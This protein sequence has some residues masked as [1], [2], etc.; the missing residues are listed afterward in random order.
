[1]TAIEPSTS[2]GLDRSEAAGRF[3]PAAI[4]FWGLAAALLPTMVLASFYFGVTWDEKSRHHYGELVWDFYTGARGM[5]AFPE[6]GGHLYGGL[7]DVLAVAAERVFP[8]NRYEIRHVIG[9]IFG[10]L[11]I[12]YAGRLAGRFFGAW[13]AVITLVLLAPSPRFFGD[14]M[15]NPK[16]LPF[17]AVS[18]VSL[19][20]ISLMSPRWPYLSFGTAVKIA[21][22]V[23]L[24]L[25][26][27]AGALL[28]A[29]Y[30]GMLAGAFFL[31]ERTYDWRRLLNLSLRLL[32]LLAAVLVMGTVAWPWAQQNPFIR[33]IIGLL[34]FSNFDYG[35]M[36]L[37]RGVEYVASEL[38]WT[39]VPTWLAIS[40]PPVVL[41]GVLLSLAPQ[42]AGVRWPRAALWFIVLLP[43]AIVVLRGSTIYDGIRHLLFIYPP[44]VL[45]AASGWAVWLSS[46]V[47]P[48]R[49][50]V[51]GVLLAIGLADVL[52]FNVR[53]FPNQIVY[54][55]QLVGGPKGAFLR[56]DMDYWG[57]CLLEAVDWS[58]A[59]ARR[60]GQP[61][62]V[63]GNPWQLIQLDSDRYK[64]LAFTLPW[65]GTEH[66]TIRLNRGPI[67][68]MRELVSRTDAL[69]QVKTPD[70]AVLCA[71]FPGPAFGQLRPNLARADR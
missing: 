27:R 59:L 9:A 5:E 51:A 61:V 64:E 35:G 43:I 6:T 39:Y 16:D 67:E 20:Y 37:F 71:V 52:I 4:A 55:N 47:G 40:T 38:P 14:A 1:M 3:T 58:A 22:P 19:Y 23:A 28:Y 63:S 17:A 66:V 11:G 36:V 34:G 62:V 7:F 44:L 13:S 53:A 15:N 2:A 41:V 12:V 56:Y 65:R 21:V 54:F 25:S 42:P 46:A 8:G 69:Y 26:I 31:A 30:A 18:V 24:A 33:P 49:R 70:G 68:G 48:R 57:N 32:G 29:G 60:S 45:I 10:W 50:L